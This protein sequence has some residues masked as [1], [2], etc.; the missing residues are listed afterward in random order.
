MEEFS[1]SYPKV[2]QFIANR[3]C[4]TETFLFDST[5][6]VEYPFWAEFEHFL[7]N[8]ERLGNTVEILRKLSSEAPLTLDIPKAWEKQRDFRSA[9]FEV[10]VIFLIEKC[11]SGKALLIPTGN[12]PTPDFEVEFSQG[13]FTI[14]AKAQ[15]GQQRGDK[16]PR[17]NGPILFDPKKETDLRSWLFEGKN[18]SRNGRAME[19]QVIAA[20]KQGA[21]ILVCQTDYVETEK[22]LLSQIS[23]LCPESQFVERMTLQVANRKPI[24]AVFFQATYPC[25]RQPIML[26]EIWLCDLSSSSYRIV[27]LSR[28]DAILSNH[29]KYIR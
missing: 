14:E 4:S 7:S 28:T 12:D 8:S 20:E 21:D 22:D 2:S 26:K 17:H 16:H 10:T 13:K 24:D 11:F 6:N 5:S 1:S 19:P 9:Q 27:V 3:P 29:L 25:A 18:S 23:I 15:S